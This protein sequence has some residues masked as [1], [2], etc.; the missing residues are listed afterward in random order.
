M[1]TS[2]ILSQLSINI[3]NFIILIKLFGQTGSAIA[4]SLL[5][6]TYS[7]PALLVGPVA[8]TFIDM[9]DKRKVLMIT[10]VLQALTIFLLALSHRTSIFILYEVVFIYSLLNQFYVPA[11]AS[12]IP[13]VLKKSDLPKG[14]GLSFITQQASLVLGFGIAGLLN[15]LMGFNNTLYLCSA[16]LF[17]A[18]ISVY[19]LP[20]LKSKLV[21]PPD[22][23]LAIKSFLDNIIEGYRFIKDKRGIMAPFL[24]LL[25]FQVALAIIIVSV[26]AIAKEIFSVNLN[27]AGIFVVI[28]AALGAMIGAF[29]LPKLIKGGLRKKKIIENSLVTLTITIAALVFVI[30]ELGYIYRILFGFVAVFFAGLAFV[31]VAIPSQTYLQEFTPYKLRGRVFGNFWFLTIIAS[32][33]PVIFSGTITEVFGVRFFLFI[34]SA[35]TFSVYILSSK[36]ADSW[37]NKKTALC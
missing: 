15:H 36:Y 7:L 21:I 24:L 14:N 3:M 23:V 16:L 6:V 12:T 13:S 17:T 20:E 28:P 10:N 8:A 9:V 37:L 22:I 26:P 11:E 25:G 2:Q 30:P 31:G 34:L 1:W 29:N 19:F 35:F 27:A 33:I 4:T 5:W 32:V 18:F